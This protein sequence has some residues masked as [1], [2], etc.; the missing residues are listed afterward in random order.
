MSKVYISGPMTGIENLNKEA[1]NEAE[2]LL[3]SQGHEVINPAVLPDGM[4]YDDYIKIAKVFIDN[5]DRIYLLKDWEKSKG[6]NIEL[7][8]YI[9]R[10]VDKIIM[11][12]QQE[13]IIAPEVICTSLP[14]DTHFNIFIQNRFGKGE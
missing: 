14:G 12:E 2:K 9:N 6:A 3:I 4:N 8:Y 5:C 1:F 13:K 10:M 7:D 11:Y